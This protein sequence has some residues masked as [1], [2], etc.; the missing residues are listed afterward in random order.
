MT[1]LP[2]Y[3]VCL[4]TCFGFEIRENTIFLNVNDVSWTRSTWKI[5]MTLDLKTYEYFM[6][7]LKHDVND[8][9]N[10]ARRVGRTVGHLL[11]NDIIFRRRSSTVIWHA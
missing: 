10:F 6:T 7:S 5:A 2:L 9:L 3:L 8:V 1:F 4:A 11:I